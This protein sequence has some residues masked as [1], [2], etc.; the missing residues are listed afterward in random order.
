MIVDPGPNRAARD[1][2]EVE[3][4]ED[5]RWE[6]EGL[7]WVDVGESEAVDAG[8]RIIGVKGRR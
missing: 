4:G 8:G 2:K 6:A 1:W 5:G 7:S 3:R